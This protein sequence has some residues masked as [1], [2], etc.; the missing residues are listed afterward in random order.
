MAKEAS[1]PVNLFK[2]KS[3][4]FRQKH[5]EKIE[6]ELILL[7]EEE[8]QDDT[9]SQAEQDFINQRVLGYKEK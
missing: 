3:E 6:T 9:L 8:F 2:E 1:I 7:S 5:H 4:E